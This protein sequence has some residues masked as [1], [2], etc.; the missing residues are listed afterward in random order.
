MPLCFSQSRSLI[1]R[2]SQQS[3]KTSTSNSCTALI[4]NCIPYLP[5]VHHFYW[6]NS[7]SLILP[8]WSE[9]KGRGDSRVIRSRARWIEFR[10]QCW[11]QYSFLGLRGWGIS[12]WSG[13]WEKLDLCTWRF[14]SWS[15]LCRGAIAIARLP[16]SE[17]GGSDGRSWWMK[18]WYQ[19]KICISW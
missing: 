8:L 9:L 11:S 14:C 15:G 12:G 2:Y 6:G 10:S 13:W 3:W 4:W 1:L 7:W 18:I 16:M 19:H 17:G 5:R